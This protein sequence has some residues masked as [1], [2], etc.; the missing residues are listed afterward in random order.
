MQI[1][2]KKVSVTFGET[3]VL[4][5]ISFSISPGE[6]V[7]LIGET[8]S[9]KSTIVKLLGLLREPCSGEVLIDGFSTT[10]WKKQDVLRYIGVILQRP[11]LVSGTVRENVLFAL[12]EEDAA[13][14]TDE[15]TW[16]LLDTISPQLR[17]VFGTRGLDRHV[18]KQGL[19]LSGGQAQRVCIARALIKRPHFL[20]VDEATSALDAENQAMVQAGIELALGEGRSAL[21]IA[22]RLS[23][24]RRCTKFVVLKMLNKCEAGEGQVEAIADSMEA[25]HEISPTFRRFTEHEGITF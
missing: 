14:V 21:V 1:E 2:L 4:R 13:R 17:E 23:T 16:R 24:L 10:Y 8:G 9:G 11:E 20:I 18:G 19:A 6:R 25:L 12:H 7:A 5:D 22:H 3:P 15:E